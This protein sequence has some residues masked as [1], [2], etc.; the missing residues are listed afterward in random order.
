M[1]HN[2][3]IIVISQEKDWKFFSPFVG[4]EALY[5]SDLSEYLLGFC[6]IKTDSALVIWNI[7][8]EKN[9]ETLL[10]SIRIDLSRW[11][12]FSE[13]MDDDFVKVVFNNSAY[14]LVPFSFSQ[15]LVK[16]HLNNFI[17]QFSKDE[18]IF[19]P[20]DGY[21]CLSGLTIS[22]LTKKEVQLLELFVNKKN[23]KVL[24]S[25]ILELVW[26]D[27]KVNSKTLDVHFYNLRKKLALYN[28]KIN[29]VKRGE[30]ELC[31]SQAKQIIIEQK[32]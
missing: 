22:N 23:K 28:I 1:I 10:R 30:W 2:N 4:R 8:D 26:K 6:S 29:L 20:Y 3:Q 11:L 13:L 21:C 12:I 24:K 17:F 18:N 9:A 15:N 31:L 16:A 14:N 32:V 7:D 25:E 19:N 27:I 5:F